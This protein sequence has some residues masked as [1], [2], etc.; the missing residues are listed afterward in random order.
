MQVVPG[1]HDKNEGKKLKKP[2]PIE[3]QQSTRKNY[4]IGWRKWTRNI[5]LKSRKKV[6]LIA[7]YP[8]K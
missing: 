1:V 6:K 5:G 3:K 8:F 2:K 4:L 7:K